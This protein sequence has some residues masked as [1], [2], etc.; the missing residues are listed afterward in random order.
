[1]AS[2]MFSASSAEPVAS[3]LMASACRIGTPLASIAPRIRQNRVIATMRSAV[4]ATGI[5]SRHRS[6]ACL[7]AGLWM[8]LQNSAT[9]PAN[10]AIRISQ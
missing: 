6:I 2:L 8:A 3:R 4:P 10:P 9:I 7:P 1:M 5:F